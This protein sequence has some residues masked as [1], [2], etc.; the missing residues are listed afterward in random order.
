MRMKMKKKK[1]LIIIYSVT[2]KRVNQ[3][4]GSLIESR[5]NSTIRLNLSSCSLS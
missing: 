4:A 3:N 2:V 1:I 5:Q